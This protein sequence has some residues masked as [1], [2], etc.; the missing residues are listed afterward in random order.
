MIDEPDEIDWPGKGPAKKLRPRGMSDYSRTSGNAEYKTSCG[1]V[2]KQRYIYNGACN[3]TKF[4]AQYR[5]FTTKWFNTANEAI[6]KLTLM[7]EG[8]K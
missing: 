1:A 5:G 7:S 4:Q 8:Q 6:Q 2:L 3:V